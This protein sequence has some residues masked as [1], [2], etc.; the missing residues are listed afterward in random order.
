[1]MLSNSVLAAASPYPYP[2]TVPVLIGWTY[3]GV[4][5]GAN[6]GWMADAYAQFGA[7]G[8]VAFS[9]ILAV[10]LRILDGVSAG[11]PRRL[12]TAIVAVPA[13]ALVNSGLLTVLLTHGFLLGVLVLWLLSNRQGGET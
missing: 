3:A 5:I 11:V 8:M 7:G 10:F 2:D 6:A 12:A 13:M 9:V 4:E 1:V